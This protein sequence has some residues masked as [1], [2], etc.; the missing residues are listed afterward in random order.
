MSNTNTDTDTDTDTDTTMDEFEF[1]MQIH[2]PFDDLL[3]GTALN[4]DHQTP[5][6]AD[7]DMSFTPQSDMLLVTT[8]LGSLDV[9]QQGPL[10]NDQF[11]PVGIFPQISI[12]NIYQ[13][14]GMEPTSAYQD[15]QMAF[16]GCYQDSRLLGTDL[17]SQAPLAPYQDNE[18]QTPEIK[19]TKALRWFKL[20]VDAQ[21][22][23][24]ID[25]NEQFP[26]PTLETICSLIKQFEDFQ[27]LLESSKAFISEESYKS[28]KTRNE[29]I[30]L[31]K[32]LVNLKA[33]KPAPLDSPTRESI[34]KEL[35]ELRATTPQLA[36]TVKR[37]IAKKYNISLSVVL[38]L[39]KNTFNTSRKAN[40]QNAPK[41]V[42]VLNK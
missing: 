20:I 8:P 3:T 31:A 38:N 39:Y 37:E 40:P 26:K 14:S 16:A 13:D 30:L 18:V 29:N 24:G 23:Y 1:R 25:P 15:N 33:L 27:L 5:P 28:R 42:K 21:C 10:P 34:K 41:A 17:V 2:G 9:N 32:I 11:I 36:T 12:D 22:F 6:F 4:Q 7:K 35:I 19:V